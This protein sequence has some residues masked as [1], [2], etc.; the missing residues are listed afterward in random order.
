VLRGPIFQ[1]DGWARCSHQRPPVR[2]DRRLDRS[3]LGPHRASRHKEAHCRRSRG[4]A[5]LNIH[6]EDIGLELRSRTPRGVARTDC[7]SWF[8]SPPQS[9]TTPPSGSP[10]RQAGSCP[11]ELAGPASRR[12]PSGLGRSVRSNGCIPAGWRST[13]AAPATPHTPRPAT[14]CPRRTRSWSSPW[15]LVMRAGRRGGW[16]WSAAVSAWGTPAK[17]GLAS[18]SPTRQAGYDTGRGPGCGSRPRPPAAG[19]SQAQPGL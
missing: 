11:P 9:P 4:R 15:G 8:R 13:R 1:R 5:G 6:H 12:T 14:R 10:R 2:K 7:R 3:L 17:R 18:I 19:A 16:V